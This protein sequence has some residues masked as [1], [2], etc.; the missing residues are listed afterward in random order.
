[1]RLLHLSDLHSFA[2]ALPLHQGVLDAALEK[3]VELHKQSPVHLL[4]VSGDL[5]MSGT[6]ADYLSVQESFLDPFVNALGLPLEQVVLVPGN[7]DVDRDRIDSIT[8]AGLVSY[9]DSLDRLRMFTDDDSQIEMALDRQS[10]WF[11]FHE[12]YLEREYK[13]VQ[14][15]IVTSRQVTLDGTVLGLVEANSA[16]RATGAPEEGDK[17]KLLAAS[18][19]VQAHLRLVHDSD[20]RVVVMH[21]PPSWMA[22]FEQEALEDVLE[23]DGTIVLT[24]HEHFADPRI[25]VTVSGV[26]AYIRSGCLF[27][28]TSYRNEFS[29]IDIDPREHELHVSMFGWVADQSRFVEDHDKAEGGSVRYELP[30]RQGSA[31]LYRPRRSHALRALGQVVAETM[32]RSVESDPKTARELLTN[33]RFFEVAYGEAVALASVARTDAE[34]ASDVETIDAVDLVLENQ[35]TIV[36]AEPGTGLTAAAV[37]LAESVYELDYRKPPVYVQYQHRGGPDPFL[38]QITSRFAAHGIEHSV[39]ASLPPVLVVLDDLR[40]QDEQTF[41]RLVTHVRGNPSSKYILACDASIVSQISQMMSD[42]SISNQT[43]H[44]GPMGR[45]EL[46][47][48]ATKVGGPGLEPQI[49]SILRTAFACGL[50]RNGF[51]M[52]VLVQVLASDPTYKPPNES[53]LLALFI[54][55]LLGKHQP[56]FRF[57]QTGLDGR[58]FEVILGEISAHY[59]EEAQIFYPRSTLETFVN[60]FYVSRGNTGVSGGHVVDFLVQQRLMHED[61]LGVRFPHESILH[62]SAARHLYESESFRQQM[63][64]QPLRYQDVLRHAAA[65]RRHDAEILLRA[66][67]DTTAVVDKQQHSVLLDDL[68][69]EQPM[70]EDE[71]MGRLDVEA[72][73]HQAISREEDEERRDARV[74][75]LERQHATPEDAPL[76]PE[77]LAELLEALDFLSEILAASELVDDAALK[78]KMLRRVLSSSAKAYDSMG[79]ESAKVELLKSVISGRLEHEGKNPSADTVETMSRIVLTFAGGFFLASRLNSPG[80][81]VS[82]QRLLDDPEFMSSP[83]Q[84]LYAA[85]LNC[86]LRPDDWA[87]RLIAVHEEHGRTSII[88]EVTRSLIIGF[89]FSPSVG[90][91]DSSLLQNCIADEAADG[92]KA[93]QHAVARRSEARSDVL[94]RLR[95]ERLRRKDTWKQMGLFELLGGE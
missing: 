95:N 58:D 56:D 34:G 94:S 47:Q 25:H 75:H 87:K 74:A 85:L 52:S 82:V 43:V 79:I 11:S 26:A 45:A 51:V 12:Y 69:R 14:D 90:V 30:S 40:G 81:G 92:V 80:L 22:A 31:D 17:G 46:R 78:L 1:M 55:N 39:G 38:R 7:H 3:V 73:S 65:L 4:V 53:S 89:S 16:F 8:E 88:G 60:D 20:V 9:L 33:P 63:L 19:L 61:E 21:H 71:M 64:A 49:D 27:G 70:G 59:I 76:L 5:A 67:Q 10:D 35:V 77:E 13:S 6:E 2:K 42:Q 24:G 93:G 62:L 84:A 18:N 54:D 86:K 29:V 91:E 28:G 68:H 15:K 37:W 72:S 57:G 41:Q 32:Y 50:P 44:V 36:V 48:L 23:R 66:D 83:S